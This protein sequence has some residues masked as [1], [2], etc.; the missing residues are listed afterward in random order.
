MRGRLVI[1]LLDGFA[2]ISLFYFAGQLHW[3]ENSETSER[4]KVKARDLNSRAFWY[5]AGLV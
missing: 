2:S 5:G 4:K 1:H 3:R